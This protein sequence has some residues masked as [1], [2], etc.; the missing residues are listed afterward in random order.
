MR[1]AV[2]DVLPPKVKRSLAKLGADL[3]LAR[4]KRGLTTAMMAKRLGI[5]RSTYARLEK[6]DA[7]VALGAYAMA[8]FVLGFGNPLAD[9]VDP[10]RDSHGLL[11]DEARVPK[12]VRIRKVP[13]AT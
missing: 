7:S 3:A 11:L 5:S 2:R 1:S 8:F 12:R 13:V 6:G 9:I 10:A 4:R